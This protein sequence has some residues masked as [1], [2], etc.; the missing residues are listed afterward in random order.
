MWSE[1]LSV[2]DRAERLQRQFFTQ[3]APAWE[4]PADIV[5]ADGELRVHIALPGVPADSITIAFDAA[6]VTVSA[7]RAFPLRDCGAEAH[8]HRVEIPYG[9]FE[10]RIEVALDDPYAPLEL[11]GKSLENGVLTLTFRTQ[12]STQLSK[13]EG[14]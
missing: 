5:E 1:A 3:V 6:G 11:S 2:L 10:R 4:P 13:K 7:L 12:L 14:A 8:I 9:R